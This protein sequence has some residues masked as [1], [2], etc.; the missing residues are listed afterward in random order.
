LLGSRL[1][2]GRAHVLHCIIAHDHVLD[3]VLVNR[4]QH[5]DQI[6]GQCRLGGQFVHQV[7]AQPVLFLPALGGG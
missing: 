3:R 1:H 6:L 2:E 4:H 5:L 7:V